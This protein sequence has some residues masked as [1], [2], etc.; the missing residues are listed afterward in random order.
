MNMSLNEKIFCLPSFINYNTLIVLYEFSPWDFVQKAV[1][2]CAPSP[3]PQNSGHNIQVSLLAKCQ[4]ISPIC[5]Y[6]STEKVLVFFAG[7]YLEFED[8][9]RR[10]TNRHVLCA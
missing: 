10:V 1:V 7:R 5:Q 2:S 3:H 6:R 4:V 8:M 9:I